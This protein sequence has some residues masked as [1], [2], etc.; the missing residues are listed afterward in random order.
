MTIALSH[1]ILVMK[2]FVN[3]DQMQSVLVRQILVK[4]GSAAVARIRNA[5][6]QN[7][8][9]MENAKKVCQF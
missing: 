3:V 4:T 6:N 7:I 2:I 5:P 8:V 1:R 9:T